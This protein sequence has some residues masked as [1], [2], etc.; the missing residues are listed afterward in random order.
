MK[1]F[2]LQHKEQLEKIFRQEGVVLAY[3]FGSQARG[4]AGPQSDIDIAALF[5]NEQK[6]GGC[7][8]RSSRL[9]ARVDRALGIHRTEI[10]C[11][12][13]A[14][15]L[16]KHRAVLCGKLVYGAGARAKRV[17]ELQALQEYEDFRY[18]LQNSYRI[19]NKHI[20]RGL[21]GKAPLSPRRERSFLNHVP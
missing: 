2:L 12:R 14:P 9:A 20:K 3:L 7:F 5:A 15:P 21:F 4:T 1:D 10:I 17:M 11:L 8:E 18:H 16:L 19:M 13:E 6:K